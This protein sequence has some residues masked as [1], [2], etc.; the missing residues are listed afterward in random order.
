M[1]PSPVPSA[2]LTSAWTSRR[3]DAVGRQALVDGGVVL[4]EQRV[5]HV[6][7]THVVVVVVPALLLRGAEHAPGGGAES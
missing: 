1:R 6:L 3:L 5:Q 7:G 2:R 4:L